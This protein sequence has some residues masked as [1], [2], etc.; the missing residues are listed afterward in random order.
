MINRKENLFIETILYWMLEQL[1]WCCNCYKGRN[2]SCRNVSV[3]KRPWYNIQSDLHIWK[4]IWEK[5]ILK[6]VLIYIYIAYVGKQMNGGNSEI[7]FWETD[8][9]YVRFLI[10]VQI[11]IL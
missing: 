2:T 4:M 6:I 9:I 8:L 10:Y 11:L 3:C 5:G 7:C 1:Q